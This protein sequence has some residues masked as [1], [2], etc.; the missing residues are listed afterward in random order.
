[1]ADVNAEINV[2]IDTSG[3]LAQLKALQR[4]ISRFHASVAKSSDAAALAQRDLQ[5]NFII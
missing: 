2:N 5:K 1:M 4:E 3:A